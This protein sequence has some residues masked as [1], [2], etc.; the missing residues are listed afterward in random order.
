MKKIRR[1]IALPVLAFL[2]FFTREILGKYMFSEDITFLHVPYRIFIRNSLSGGH[3]PL[4]IHNLYGGI[5]IFAEGQSG[6]FFP[7]NYIFIFL[8]NAYQGYT[9]H[10]IFILLL[11]F[12]GQCLLT[13][14][15]GYR[16][17]PSA[18]S[19][20][21]FTLT[22]PVLARHIFINMLN[23]VMLIPWAMLLMHKYLQKRKI[24]HLLLLIILLVFQFYAYHPQAFILS[25]CV[26]IFYAVYIMQEMRMK[27]KNGAFILIFIFFSVFIFA[28]PQILPPL[29]LLL[30]NGA[31]TA[32]GYHWMMKGSPNPFV[33][34][35]YFF[36]P[37]PVGRSEFFPRLF[38]RGTLFISVT[39]TVLAYI[40]FYKD[41]FNKKTAFWLAL[42]IISA[43]MSLGS[44]NP[45][46]LL[47]SK[48]PILNGFRYQSRWLMVS[49]F[50]MGIL[51]ARG[52]EILLKE[53]HM[54]KKAI[55]PY[56]VFVL[57]LGAFYITGLLIFKSQ[58]NAYDFLS[59]KEFSNVNQFIVIALLGIL[60]VS[61]KKLRYLTAY[62][63]AGLLV[64]E[65]YSAKTRIIMTAPEKAI[66][67]RTDAVKI[68]GM[69]GWILRE[70][71]PFKKGYFDS[72]A[73]YFKKGDAVRCTTENVYYRYYVGNGLINDNNNCLMGFG[74][75]QEI[76]ELLKNMSGMISDTSGISQKARFMG[77]MGIG[78]ILTI[79][80][81]KSPYM[82]L[83]GKY[84]PHK[85]Y[86][87]TYARGMVYPVYNIQRIARKKITMHLHGMDIDP[88]TLL[89]EGAHA[90][91][92]FKRPRNPAVITL[93]RRKNNKIVIDFKGNECFLFIADRYYPGWR[94]NMD[95]AGVK[96]EK[97]DGYWKAI[98]VPEGNH[99]ITLS[100]VPWI[101][102]YGFF[103]AFLYIPIF[104][105]ILRTT[106]RKQ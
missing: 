47:I 73:V 59:L 64:F 50:A 4:W 37:S 9:Y 87:D 23:V 25:S 31:N 55:L 34:W 40:A 67:E 18:I 77:A 20:A 93:S 68:N 16:S 76:A 49:V 30:E 57:L 75:P 11:G 101:I 71:D 7:L 90:I 44:V 95:G 22:G 78:T 17:L 6:I 32:K 62:L 36:F 60:I 81:I 58:K 79:Q 97:A 21:L 61:S 102:F 10:I 41:R 86:R 103:I 85:V 3:F 19:G 91:I 106:H 35:P 29:Q 45:I 92:H 88:D 69:Y 105:I 1:G 66:A 5:P 13:R 63:Y 27:A 65:L 24:S 98:H 54:L 84:G 82:P 72:L 15:L 46:Y 48:I 94:A 56:L 100:Y 12:I 8:K 104:A 2:L 89:L 96:I 33:F 43:F 74:P 26:L 38:G 53:P 99:E 80:D 14:T 28:L 70:R 39:G 83:I 42:F 52:F 51:A